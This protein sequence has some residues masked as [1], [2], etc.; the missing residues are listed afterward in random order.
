M[1]RKT[2]LMAIVFIGLMLSGC[3]EEG[4]RT[5]DNNITD[6]PANVT[7]NATANTSAHVESRSVSIPLEKPPF[8]EDQ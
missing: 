2:L 5:A 7:D 3:V 1:S 8:I 4:V 6:V